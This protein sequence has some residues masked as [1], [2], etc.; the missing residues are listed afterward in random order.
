MSALIIKNEVIHYEVLGRGRPLLLLHGWVGSWR[1]WLPTMQAVSSSY[2][3]YALD[4]WGYGDTAKT[5]SRYTIVA[6]TELVR[7]FMEELGIAKIA[8]LGHG[9]GAVVAS[10]FAELHPSL[11]DRAMFV[12]YPHD[13]SAINKRMKTNSPAELSRW[14]L[15]GLPNTDGMYREAVKMDVEVLRYIFDNLSVETLLSNLYTLELPR[16]FVY[17]END[18]AITQPPESLLQELGHQTH[19]M[20]LEENGH[21]PMLSDSSKF[22][23]LVK[24]FLTLQAQ[25]SPQNLQLKNEWKRRFR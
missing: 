12:G 10:Q 3:C 4:L 16:L 2:R 17:G 18:P 11:V 13:L 25:E 23:R 14:L 7:S 24:D 22:S 8:I 20:V 19:Y 6:Q 1:D 9:F 21:Y 15:N 5:K